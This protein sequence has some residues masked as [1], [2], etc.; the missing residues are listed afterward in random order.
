MLR[1]MY[2]PA[3]G[4]LQTG[5]DKIDIAYVLRDPDGLFWVDIEGMPPEEAAPL[6]L[7]TFKFH[8]LAVDDALV[9]RHV[10]KLDDWGDYLYIVL[11]A[12]TVDASTQDLVTHELDVFLGENYIVTHHDHSLDSINTVWKSI[13]LDPR[14]LKGGPDRV[15]Y[16][17]LDEIA[18]GSMAAIEQLDDTI[19]RLETE[20]FGHPQIDLV[21]SVFDIKRSM[22]HLRRITAPQREVLNRLA[23]DEFKM[24][25][26][27]DR[28][29][30]RDV[31]DHYVRLTELIES[32]RDLVSGTLDTYLSVTNNRMN[33]IM[34]TL[35][36]ITT[37]FMPLTFLTGFFGMNFFSP[38]D[39]V[40]YAGTGRGAFI[41]AMLLFIST[42]IVMY[43][44]MMRRGWMKS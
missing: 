43:I 36:L 29:Y 16:R 6:L 23:R 39:P 4:R 32:V 15:L 18:S 9:E 37:L 1:A 30:F 19:D 21:E 7:N 13:E 11:H 12:P 28:V 42:P 35:T 8:P 3:A 22:L 33:E 14:Y 40:L 41:A 2:L 5:L 24:I 20:V 27:Q 31:Y 34:K 26:A 38:V 10:P 25:D 17:V 44:W